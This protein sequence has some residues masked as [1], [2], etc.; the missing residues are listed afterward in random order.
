MTE[1]KSMARQEK[2]RI[3]YLDI[4]KGLA[5]LFMFT[6]HCMLVHE[7]TAGEGTNILAN[8]FVLLGTA[9]AAPIFMLIMGVFLSASKSNFTMNILRGIKLIALGYLL[10]LLRFTLPLFIAGTAG[11]QY[12]AGETPLS[13]FLS[14]DIL[15]LAGL[16][17][18]FGSFLKR[19]LDNKIVAPIIIVAILICSPLLWENWG[20][21]PIFSILWGAGKNV[22]FPFFPWC[23]YPIIGMS[24]SRFLL[25]MSNHKK[26]I[27]TLLWSGFFIIVIGIGTFDVFP[28]GDYHRSGA[29]IHF[30]MIGFILVWL[31]ACRWISNRF[32][33]TCIIDTLVFWSKNVT[34][35]YFIQWVLFG[36]SI[37]IFGA[38]KQNAYVA[39]FIGLIVL[40]ATHLLVKRNVV[41]NAFSWI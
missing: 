31:S 26:D 34:A 32:S 39:A 29:A 28:V 5:I 33:N 11:F 37:L 30:L 1:E 7:K 14:V 4:A 20:D 9:P 40:I 24:L 15:Q 22:Y 6:Q 2:S 3:L 12:I 41:K 17:I 25:D 38:N 10:N 19:F 35:V 36:W 23:V 27:R 8:I 18:I 21:K 13:M 16:S